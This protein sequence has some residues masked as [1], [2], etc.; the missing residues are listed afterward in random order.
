MIKNAEH[1]GNDETRSYNHLHVRN[2]SYFFKIRDTYNYYG[3]FFEDGFPI[4]I[5]IRKILIRKIDIIVK[6][7]AL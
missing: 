1:K 7:F 5:K 6:I 3:I 2:Y 4:R